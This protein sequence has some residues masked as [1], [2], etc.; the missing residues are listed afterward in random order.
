MP[1]SMPSARSAKPFDLP[2]PRGHARGHALDNPVSSGSVIPGIG[3]ASAVANRPFQPRPEAEAPEDPIL[4]TFDLTPEGEG[5]EAGQTE[6]SASV[7]LGGKLFI[8]SSGGGTTLQV[9]DATDPADPT[10]AELVSREP[11]GDYTTQSVATWGNLVAVALSPV[12]YDVDP[13][14]GL[15]RFY[16]LGPDGSLGWIEDVEVGYLPDSIAFSE[17]GKQVVVANEGQ[18]N[19]GVPDGQGG[20]DYTQ[21]YTVD[22]VG[23]IGI[24]D[25]Q[26]RVNLGFSY[27]DLTFDGVPLPTDLR[28]SGPTGTTSAQDIEPEYVSILGDVAFVTLQENNG[29]ARVNLATREIT[30]VFALGTVNY[31]KQLVD[32]TNED[33]GFK[34]LLG[35]QIEG[36]DILGLLM[37]DGIAAYA[38]NGQAYFLTANEGDGRVYADVD[39][40]DPV[41]DDEKRRG[42]A[43]PFDRLKTLREIDQPPYTAFGARSVSLFDGET[44]ELLWD[45]G[46]TLQTIAAAALQY[47]DGRS[48]DKGVEPETVVTAEVDGRT[49]AIVGM[50]RTESSMLAVFDVTVPTDVAFVTS[51]V[52]EGSLSPE[53]LLVVPARQSP[54]GRA[55]LVVSNEVSNTLDFIDLPSLIEAPAVAEAGSFTDTMLKDVTGGPDLEITSLITNGEFTVGFEP[56]SVYAPNGIFDGMGAFDN[57]DGTYTLL[58]NS[59]L[60]NSAGYGY[61]INDVVLTGARVHKFIVDKDVDDD[62]SNGVQSALIQGGLAYHTIY[63]PDGSQLDEIGD[64]VE[65]RAGFDRF[66]SAVLVEAEQ[67]GAGRGLADRVFFTGEETGGSFSGVS[68]NQW[69]LDVASGALWAVPTMGRGAWENVTE[70]DTGTTTHVAFILM[71]DTSPFDANGD[72]DLEVAPMFLYVGEKGLD[73]EGNSS[74]DFLARNGLAY[75]KLYVWVADDSS[76]TDFS[77]F[78]GSMNN[79]PQAGAWKEVDNTPDLDQASEDGSTGFDEYGYPTQ[80]NLWTQAKDLGAFGFS[81]PEDVATNPD[82]GS[83]IVFASTGTSA[84]GGADTFGTLYTAVLDFSDLDAPTATVSILYDGDSEVGAWETANGPIDTPTERAD[85][86]ATIIRSPD[87]LTWSGD[88][89]IYVQEDRSTLRDYFA[90]EETSIWQVDPVTGQSSATRWSQIDRGTVPG[91]YGQTDPRSPGGDDPDPGNWESSGI[92]DVSAIYDAD[93]GTYFL[94]DVQAHSLR[95]GNL[96]GGGYLVEGGQILLIESSP[97]A[98]I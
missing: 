82:N 85:F 33:D 79:A 27:T 61:L 52:V 19:I 36:D 6:I 94:A 60:G 51:A 56:G 13:Q 83:E 59:E 4:G 76:I 77:N 48:D 57:E 87:N 18:P 42:D 5:E 93:P 39:D 86:G 1:G 80:R 67:F 44:G 2:Q 69:A 72:G 32:L 22:P 91:V 70:V 15:V 62:P 45:S 38:V 84:F 7:S 28:I 88:G 17:D 90:A 95:D 9:S 65:N 21:A 31:T 16:R 26:G 8:I 55:Q 11:L 20:I 75:G 81:R 25:I 89:L 41:Y 92:I 40:V 49:Y 35:Q 74:D 78:N 46:T 3:S 64:L 37:P 53:G 10:A 58:V 29:V 47:D 97:A 54:T 30:D 73:L 12:D 23:S 34:P 24:I 98:A 96:Y 71:D 50:E 43:A 68:G 66:C 14:K 63:T